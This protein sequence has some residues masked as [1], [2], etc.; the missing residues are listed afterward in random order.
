MRHH[1]HDGAAAEMKLSR[2]SAQERLRMDVLKNDGRDTVHLDL[3]IEK[4]V[5]V[6]PASVIVGALVGFVHIPGADL[7]WLPLI[8]DRPAHFCADIDRQQTRRVTWH[9]Q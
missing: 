7:Y 5:D 4:I 1:L 2:A 3:A 6:R 8:E 9:R